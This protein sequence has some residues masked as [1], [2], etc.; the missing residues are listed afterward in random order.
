VFRVSDILTEGQDVEVMVLAVDPEQQRISLSL[1]A[2][3]A[4]AS[5]AAQ[6]E[7]PEQPEATPETHRKRNTPL[8]GGVG[9]PVTGE[10]FGLKW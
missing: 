3:E 8:K 10:K 9:G 7:E 4:R 2:I 1:K 5:E 6:P